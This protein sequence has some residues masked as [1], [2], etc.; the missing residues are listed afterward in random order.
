M[1]LD[2]FITWDDPKDK[3]STTDIRFLL[4]DYL[5]EAGKIT[6]DSSMFTALLPGKPSHPLKRLEPEFVRPLRDERWFEVHCG[7]LLSI[8]VLTREADEFTN[9]VAQGFAEL[10][11]RWF[12]G[13]LE[14]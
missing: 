8:D 10:V 14:K 3:P 6:S 2:R 7:H 12:K 13:D 11:A 5:G 1:A 9:N 4:E